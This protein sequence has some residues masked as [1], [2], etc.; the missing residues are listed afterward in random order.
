MKKYDFL[1]LLLIFVIYIF[2]IF[3]LKPQ[4]FSYKFTNKVVDDFL[5]S[6]NIFG[7]VKNRIFVSDETIYIASG[8]LYAKGANPTQYNFEHPPFLKY[9]FGLATIVFNN[10]YIAQLIF[11]LSFLYLTYFLGRKIL[12][13]SFAAFLTVCLVIFDPLFIS[14]SSEILLDMGHALFSLSYVITAV[15]FPSQFILYG[16][17]LGLS[18][19]SKFWAAS[20]FYVG[21]VIINL[22]LSKKHYYRH[23]IFSI[24]I[25]SIVYVLIYL[26]TFIDYH[27]SFNFVFFQ[28]KMLRY[29]IQHNVSA[30]F[31]ASIVLFN[32]GFFKSWWGDH[33]VLRSNVWSIFWPLS[34]IIILRNFIFIKDRYERLI[35]IIVPVGYLFY[36][37][38]QA[39]FARY[40]IPIIPLLYINLTYSTI[41]SIKIKGLRK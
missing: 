27:W 12:M 3:L 14:L 17:A 16:I 19:S 11:G 13:N 5:H 8:Y 4:V 21:I 1:F 23:F 9:V 34:F 40:F 7:D 32:T 26:K 33:Q 24:L 29:W 37:G 18:A 6:Q 25:A 35:L 30:Y 36:L 10:P 2:S 39:P 22:F 20:L 15:F 38:I 41:N 28:L 31:G